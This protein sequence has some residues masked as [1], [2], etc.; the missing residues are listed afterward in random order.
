MKTTI[1]IIENWNIEDTQELAMNWA[2]GHAHSAEEEDILYRGFMAGFDEGF[3]LG[4]QET[5]E[6]IDE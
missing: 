4:V 3:G 6:A 5:F 1:E 2:K